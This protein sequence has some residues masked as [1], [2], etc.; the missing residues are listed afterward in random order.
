MATQV[1]VNKPVDDETA[2]WVIHYHV[3]SD[4]SNFKGR[5][6]FLR[7]LFED[8]ATPY[9]DSGDHM[10]GPTGMMDCFRGSVDAIN[11]SKSDD[12]FPFP[13]LFPPAIWHRPKDSDGVLI[14]QVGACLIY[15]G[16][17]L[18]YAPSSDAEKARAN[19]IMLNALDYISEGRKSFHPV[20]NHM[21]YK[22]QK[23]EGDK[24]SKKFSETRMLT[25]LHHFNKVVTKNETARQPIAGGERVTYA[26]FCLFHVLDAT[27]AQ[28]NSEFYEKAW[29]NAQVPQLKEYHEWIGSRPNLQTYFRSDRWLRKSS[30]NYLTTFF[31]YCSVFPH[32]T[33]LITF[34]NRTAFAGDSMM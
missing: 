5:A 13:V 28:F 10:Y 8:S 27:K 20:E 30:F 2:E 24:Q 22:D 15:L 23:E 19:C 12:L 14:N 33:D 25:F 17:K 26:D 9:V 31:R 32:V 16:D 29:D 7:L 11:A 18:G 34:S 3:N 4:G 21:S 1:N 6:E